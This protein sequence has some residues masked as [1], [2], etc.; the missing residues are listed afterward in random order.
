M[1]TATLMLVVSR[2]WPFDPYSS[3]G[4]L[5]FVSKEQGFMLIQI[6]T[7]IIL[8]FVTAWSFRTCALTGMTTGIQICNIHNIFT[9][10]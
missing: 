7:W 6:E 1:T 10:M 9:C 4:W 8:D 3:N 5:Q 2:V